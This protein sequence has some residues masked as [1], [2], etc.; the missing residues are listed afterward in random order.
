MVRKAFLFAVL[1][2]ALS[3]AAFADS[4][5][6]SNFNGGDLRQ[7]QSQLQTPGGIGSL[8]FFSSYGN[9]GGNTLFFSEL[10]DGTYI[11][12]VVNTNRGYF[13]GFTYIFGNAVV[14]TP[15]ASSLSFL[16]ISLVGLAFAFRKKLKF[17]QRSI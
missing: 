16:M 15:D 11:Q 1:S 8:G 12:F 14:A 3:G 17:Q 2:L 10:F 4:G 5:N 9:K 7:P 6:L 13:N